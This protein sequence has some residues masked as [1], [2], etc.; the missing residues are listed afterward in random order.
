MVSVYPEMPRNAR[1]EAEKKTGICI[2]VFF[3]TVINVDTNTISVQPPALMV[4]FSKVVS[5]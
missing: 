3:E 1:D 4:A 2:P 5:Q